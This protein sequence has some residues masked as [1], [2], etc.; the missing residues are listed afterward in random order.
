MVEYKYSA[1][2]IQLSRTGELANTLGY[3]NPFRYRGYIYDEETGLYYLRSRYYNPVVGRFV[4]ADDTIKPKALLSSVYAYCANKPVI[5]VDYSGKLYLSIELYTIALSARLLEKFDFSKTLLAAK[6]TQR[7]RASKVVKKR[8]AD[9]IKA[10]PKGE[11]SYSKTEKIYW[12]FNE[13]LKNLS[14]SD[15]DLALAVGNASDMTITV[16]KVEK[17]FFESIFFWG[18][19]Y[20]VTY[21]LNDRYDFDRWAG[22]ERDAALIWLNDTLG[23]E[24]QEAGI[25]KKYD[26][27]CTDS[28]Y[29]YAF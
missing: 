8:V 16:E 2:G 14:M 11:K 12:G 26:Y 5:R 9:Y 13:S 28:Y 20:K 7:I 23:Y 3:A 17:G 25:L 27:T 1:W 24:P 4:N 10:I 29:V 22:T 18:D 15:L 19:K 6:F 21:T